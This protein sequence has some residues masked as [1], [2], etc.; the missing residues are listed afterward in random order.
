MNTSAFIVN[1][2]TLKKFKLPHPVS[3][4]NYTNV[5]VHICYFFA[6]HESLNEHKILNIR[7]LDIRSIWP[8]EPTT[9]E[10]MLFSMSS[11]SWRKIDVELPVDISLE[12]QYLGYKQSVCVNIVIHLMIVSKN[13]ILA[14]DLTKEKFSII[15]IPKDAISNKWDPFLMKINGLLGV[16]CHD[17]ALKNNE[18]Y[19]WILQDYENRVWVRKTV[20]FDESWVK[21]DSPFPLDS[22]STNEIVFSSKVLDWDM[23][24]V[25]IYYLTTGKF[26]S[27]KFFLGHQFFR[28][29]FVEFNQ[30]R[31]YVESMLPLKSNESRVF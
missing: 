9:I 4:L 25:P 29:K 1:L 16:I 31:S 6:F 8:F 15:N 2:S 11:Y 26:K 19:I 22:V 23:I 17:R 12:L 27:V 18:M 14:F 24:S 10:F 20:S 3:T 30:V 5:N 28:Y 13:A 7:M 21:L